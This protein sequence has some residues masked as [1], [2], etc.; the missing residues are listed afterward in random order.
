M[1]FSIFSIVLFCSKALGCDAGRKD[2]ICAAAWWV[3]YVSKELLSAEGQLW[4]GKNIHV[5]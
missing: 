5:C 1:F 4:T 2:R 3:L